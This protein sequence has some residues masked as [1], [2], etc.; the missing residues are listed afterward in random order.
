MCSELLGGKILKQKEIAVTDS[1]QDSLV[2]YPLPYKVVDGCLYKEI[3]NKSG[4]IT[5]KLCNFLPYI[6][7]EV[8]IDD[9]V[10]VKTLL[11]LG[12]IHSSGRVLPE[13]DVT[14]NELGNFNWLIERWGAD[15]VLEPERSVKEYVRHAIQ[16]TAESAERIQIYH[17]TGWKLIDGEWEYLLPNDGKHDVSLR[18]K[19]SRYEKV[20]NWSVSDLVCPFF[21]TKELSFAPEVITLPLLAHTFLTPLNE[22]LHQA[23][24]EPKFV[25]CL[26]GKTGTRK[27]T[28]AA[29]FLSFYGRFTGSDLPLSFRDTANSIMYNAFSLKDVLTCIDDFHPSGRKEVNR[30]TETAQLIMR[31][32][33][34]RIG[35]G[36][37]KSDSTPMESRPPQGNA[38]ITAEQAP[39]IGES[40]TARYFCLELRDKMIDLNNLSKFQREAEKGTLR[41]CL[42]AYTEWIKK[43][44]LKDKSTELMFVNRLKNSF[45][46]YRNE[47]IH[48]GIHC[49]GRVPEIYAWLMIGME[50]FLSFLLDYEVISEED[51]RSTFIRC[52]DCLY[53]LAK[54]QSANIENDKPTHKFVQKLYSLIESGQAVLLDRNNPVEFKPVNYIGYQDDDYFYLNADIAHKQVKRLCSEQEESFSISKN[55]LI[56][57]L[58]EEGLTVCDKGKNTKSIR[59]GDKTLR[60]ICLIREKADAIAELCE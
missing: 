12:G 40:G 56:K 2:Q 20:E 55:G 21:M 19:L 33:G 25:L 46:K 45:N 5:K 9:G 35:R 7:S 39:D 24:C 60:F 43:K 32:Y 50:Y 29:L 23:N 10:E 34:D 3:T 59:I 26:L 6:V 44:F 1:Q 51:Y 16:Q 31:G 11:R 4:T 15:C 14:G 28:L 30:L 22:F 38:I 8:S 13:T 17:V 27:S 42:L 41:R 48:S 58:A 53:G 52:R 18:G 57:A 49:H 37:L 47:F 54:K 36:R